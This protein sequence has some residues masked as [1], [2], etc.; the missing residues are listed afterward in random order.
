MGKSA[1]L[2]MRGALLLTVPLMTASPGRLPSGLL[3]PVTI[4][5]S[6]YERPSTTSPS[7]GTRAPDTTCRTRSKLSSAS[8]HL[9]TFGQLPAAH[10]PHNKWL[11][12]MGGM[13]QHRAAVISTETP[14]KRLMNTALNHQALKNRSNITTNWASDC[15]QHDSTCAARIP[16]NVHAP[17]CSKCTPLCMQASKSCS[18]RLPGMLATRHAAKRHENRKA[19]SRSDLEEVAALYE[20]GGDLL[21]RQNTPAVVAR[22]QRGCRWRQLQ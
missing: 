7:A 19:E 6:T 20:G 15:A 16:P 22:H 10:R 17:A 5:S 18:R 11:S 9:L 2:T 1:T 21:L 8:R 12:G 14:N 13:S 3:S 4:D